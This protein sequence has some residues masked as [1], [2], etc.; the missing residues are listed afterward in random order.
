[1][2]QPRNITSQGG[3]FIFFLDREA[4]IVDDRPTLGKE[5]V[6]YM[7]SYGASEVAET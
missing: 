1:V 7:S 6:Q 2:R 3:H 5:V 4:E